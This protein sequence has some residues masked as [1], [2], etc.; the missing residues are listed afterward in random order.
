MPLWDEGR[1]VPQLH[2]HQEGDK[3]EFRT[4]QRNNSS[5]ISNFDQGYP[6]VDRKRNKKFKWK[7]FYDILKKNKKFEWTK[8][9]KDAFQEPKNI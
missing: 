4:N 5:K 1:Q 8:D 7:Y 9:H 2:G 3:F 6:D